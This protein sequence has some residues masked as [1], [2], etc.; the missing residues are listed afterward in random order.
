MKT[1]AVLKL[2]PGF[3]ISRTIQWEADG[4]SLIYA[5]QN[6]GK[7]KLCR[8]SINSGPPQEITTLRAEDEFE[9]SLSPNGKQ[10]AYVSSKWNH[11]AVLIEG[12]K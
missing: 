7:L 6:E 11:Y 8:Q 3:W 2:A 12:F 10:L 1:V 9:F 4:K 5:I